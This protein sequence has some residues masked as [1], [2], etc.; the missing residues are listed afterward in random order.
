MPEFFS[1]VACMLVI[2]ATSGGFHALNGAV[3]ARETDTTYMGRVMSL[4]MLAFA[5]FGLTALPLG[6]MADRFG[7]RTVLAGMGLA[8]LG[9]SLLMGGLL[10][11]GARLRSVG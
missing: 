7:E 5:G 8:V 1:A 4:T 2:G 6:V 10:A 9:L 3:I 11:R